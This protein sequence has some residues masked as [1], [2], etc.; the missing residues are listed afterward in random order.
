[1]N[2]SDPR[3]AGFTRDPG[4]C[5]PRL[6]FLR[7]TP[8]PLHSP[9]GTVHYQA[10]NKNSKRGAERVNFTHEN[11]CIMGKYSLQWKLKVHSGAHKGKSHRLDQRKTCLL[12]TFMVLWL[13]QRGLVGS[14]QGAHV[15]SIYE[16][17]YKSTYTEISPH[18][19]M[20]P[21]E[22]KLHSPPLT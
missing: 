20:G 10:V 21:A 13:I 11:S 12:A 9:G 1:M 4:V 18:T 19:L 16:S 3:E 7:T 22:R 15:G 6:F 2:L 8:P 14:G 17:G 5:P